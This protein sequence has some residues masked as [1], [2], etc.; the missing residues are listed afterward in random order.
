MVIVLMLL[1][2]A[3]AFTLVLGATLRFLASDGHGHLPD[4][5]SHRSWDGTV[6]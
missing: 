2:A 6:Y 5:P 1:A 4:V 3:V